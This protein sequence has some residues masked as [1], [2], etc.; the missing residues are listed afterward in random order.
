MIF[1]K[2][3][4]DSVIRLDSREWPDPI[5]DSLKGMCHIPNADKE[6]MRREKVGGWQ[7]LPSTISL[8]DFTDYEVRIPRG[9]GA[10]LNKFA[11]SYGHKIEWEDNRFKLHQDWGWFDDVKPIAI[12]DYQEE[13]LKAI[14]RSEQGYWKSPPGSGKT[15]TVLE[16]IRRSCSSAL[17]ITNTTN[18]AEQWRQRAKQFLG[19]DIGII[20]DGKF[21]IKPITIAM[22]QT[23]W[24]RREELSE[25]DFFNQWR[26]VC[27][28]ECHHLP[29]ETFT[30]TLSRFT[31]KFRI[32]VSGTP[33]KQFAWKGLLEATLGP[34]I[35]ETPKKILQEKGWLIKPEVHAIH[36]GFVYDFFSTHEHWGYKQNK[37]CAEPFC[38]RPKDKKR[39]GNNYQEMV[40]ALV[41]DPTR[42]GIIQ[43]K[44]LENYTDGNC[45][46]VLSRRLQHLRDFKNWLERHGAERV[47]LLTGKETTEQRMKVAEDAD[48]GKCVILS[49]LADEALDI[50][51]IDRIHLAF[52]SKNVDLIRQQIGRGER[53]H[54]DKTNV[55][56][57][58]YVDSAGPLQN[59]YR[60]RRR[61]YVEEGMKIYE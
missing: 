37:K 45:A 30:D 41:L 38:D 20:G 19:V 49:T 1:M 8:W 44:I 9:L 2:A 34:I 22:Q 48:D 32:G 28:D 40:S 7:R 5:L 27:L 57:Y 33:T 24:A 50:P 11:Q 54:P 6:K 12:R 35:H 46:L 25:Q 42:Y 51:R 3:V 58:D 15:V 56:V 43:R 26:F 47:F 36:T 60:G 21:D 53:P 18:I 10:H 31:A 4:V 16:A 17:V 52:P 61:M 39:H 59:Q 55:L 29:A 23:L 13:A 14:L